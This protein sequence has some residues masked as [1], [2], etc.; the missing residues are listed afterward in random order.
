M[1]TV[2]F[3]LM[4]LT[5]GSAMA[6]M[7][8]AAVSRAPLTANDDVER[9]T[10]YGRQNRLVMN[11][12]LATK[13]DMSLMET[14]AAIVLVDQ[15]LIESQGAGNLQDLVRNI[16]G[17]TQ[18]GNNYG[19]G[20]N[21]S[22]RGLDT[23]YT[24]DG[25][26]GGA[27]LGN[28]FNPTRSLTNVESV[29]V[30]KGPATGLYGMGSAGGIINLI[31]KKPRF[32]AGTEFKAELGQWDSYSLALDTTGAIAQDTAYRLVAKHGRS[33]GY[34]QLGTDRDEIYASL[35]QRFG[36]SQDLLF[37]VAYIQDAVRVDSI[38]DPIRIFN[39]D[40]V[41]GK[42][43]MEVSWQDLVNDP[44]GKGVNLSDSQRQQLADSLRAGDGLT[45]F[46]LGDTSLLSSLTEPNQGEELRFKLNHNLDLSDNLYLNQQLQYRDYHSDFVRQTGAYN[47]V[48]WHRSGATNANPRAPLV[49]DGVLYPYAARR[50]EYRKVDA[51]ETSWQ[52]F[53]DLRYDFSLAGIDSELLLNAN[54][55]DRDI[56]LQDWSIYDADKEIKGKNG[57]LLYLG[58]LP[59]L[60][61]IR[62]PN[63]GTGSFEQYDPLLTANYS[64]QVQ[65]WGLGLQYVGYLSDTLTT[66]LGFAFNEIAQSYTHLGVDSRYSTSKAEPIPEKNSKDNGMTYNLGLSYH[67]VDELS[68]FINHAK[69]RIAYSLLGSVSGQQD[70]RPDSES[71]SYDLGIRLKQFDDQLLASLV[72]FQ[73][74]RTNLRYTNPDYEL[75]ISA[76][77][78]PQ[79]FFNGA[80]ETKGVELDINAFLDEQW[81]FNLNGVYQDARNKN[82][83]NSS[84]YNSHQKGVP[85]ITAGAWLSYSANLAMLPQPLSLSLGVNYVAER[86]TASSSFGIPDG[87][88]DAYSLWHSAIAYDTDDW[89]LQ[90]NLNNL[91]NRDYYDKAM[92]LGGL[93]GAE[94]NLK[95]SLSYR[96]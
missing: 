27:G 28:S 26:Y 8:H 11:S 30:L 13:S 66:R 93:P 73:S 33:D 24:Y 2:G 57:E 69:G 83:P 16:S 29:E 52:Y 86:S 39:S 91:F 5:C 53:A 59:Y 62:D 76:V 36:P 37:S 80:D 64:K 20:D 94:C 58:Q 25:M 7:S 81:K 63:W 65:A 71:L 87:H 82:D 23:S 17:V 44:K 96:L 38:G 85:M 78:V 32:D 40:S 15:A 77:E 90:L 49:V 51:D 88:V 21:L 50:Q 14:P 79:Y 61:D 54:L 3:S 47:Y 75:G 42:S 72:L 56:R 89:S 48:Y 34:R 19:I 67:P 4:L 60:L 45:P 55:E 68:L 22:I 46:A 9:I 10:V 70:D 84:D 95:L 35:K 12:G 1:R 41:A 74:S 6:S 18:A 31:E 92:F 43:A